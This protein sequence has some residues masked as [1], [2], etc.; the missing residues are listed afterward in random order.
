MLPHLRTPSAIRP[1]LVIPYSCPVATLQPPPGSL[2]P[3]AGRPRQVSRLE[4]AA[5]AEIRGL[6]AVT[7]GDALTHPRA[8]RLPQPE[9]SAAAAP[10]CAARGVTR[11]NSRA[12]QKLVRG[13]FVVGPLDSTGT[14]RE[15]SPGL[16][17]GRDGAQVPPLFT[18]P[19]CNGRKWLQKDS[20]A[21]GSGR[22]ARPV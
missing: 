18:H 2:H 19:T 5:P 9:R 1:A 17:R 11:G 16:P 21:T 10:H 22:A 6:S 20:V 12:L 3:A 15:Q 14:G 7:R 4:G 8:L 13:V